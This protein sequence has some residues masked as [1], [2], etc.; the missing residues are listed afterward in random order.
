MSNVQ[1]NNGFV[2][3]EE[4]GYFCNAGV[5]LMSF[6]DFYAP[7]HQCGVCILKHGRRVASN[8]DL[9][10][11]QTPGQWQPLPKQEKRE[12]DAAANTITTTLSYPDMTQHLRGFNPMIYPDYAF[13][14]RVTLRGE[15]EHLVVTVD[16]DKPVPAV[17]QGK[18]CFNLELFP[19]DLF[20]KPW[21]M[22]DQQG[23]FP[24]QPNGPSPAF[25][26]ISDQTATL[27]P[28]EAATPTAA[29]WPRMAR[30]TAPLW[31][32]T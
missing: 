16:L 19:G 17:Y 25:R 28:M 14:Y 20:G 5:D 15:G 4:K 31:P 9:R 18:M 10:F 1:P 24:R 2:L 30:H 11:E 12:V 29:C 8:G 23:I 3:N 13:S 21:I 26:A 27:A 7:G 6:R 22:D 32:T